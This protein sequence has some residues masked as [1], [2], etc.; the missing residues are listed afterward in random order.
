M[1]FDNR[2]L[3]AIS[4]TLTELSNLRKV[5]ILLKALERAKKRTDYYALDLSLPELK[6]TF[7]EVA[8]ADYKYVKFHALHGSYDDGLAWL[9]DKQ[10]KPVV[11]MSLGSSIGNFDRNEAAKFL[12]TFSTGMTSQD[13]FIVGLDACQDPEKVFKAYNDS[14]GVTERFYRNGL[15]HANSLLGEKAFRQE[16][17][18]VEGHYS[19]EEN[20]HEAFY[21]AKK[22]LH[23]RDAFIRRGEK[24]KFEESYKY[25][26]EES[27]MM[28]RDAELVSV[29]SY[30]NRDNT[31]RMHFFE[32]DSVDLR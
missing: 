14:E 21:V 4:K 11:I 30:G 25:S 31:H 24:L 27:D 28:W 20:K 5:E 3:S 8:T 16:D 13:M 9:M 22:D 2:K 10:D 7:A 18:A 32:T 1:S 15:D 6:R 12:T 23:I 29:C 17:W 19:T 26:I